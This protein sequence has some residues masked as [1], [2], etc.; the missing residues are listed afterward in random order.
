[1]ATR[2]VG[3]PLADVRTAIFLKWMMDGSKTLVPE[4]SEG[5]VAYPDIL[6]LIPGVDSAEFLDR[7]AAQGILKKEKYVTEILCPSCG[8]SSLRDRYTCVFCHGDN[9]ETGE[10]IEHY[11]CGNTDL[12]INFQQEGK[13]ICTKCRRELKIIG[14]DYRRVGKV[15]KCD[16][17]G[18]ESSIPRIA[19]SCQNCGT[20]STWEQTRLLRLYKYRIN[21]EKRKEIDSLTGIYLPL[22]EFLRNGGFQVESP[23]I[24]RGESGTEHSFDILAKFE[25]TK[26]LFDMAADRESVGEAVV[27]GLF[28]KTLDVPHDAAVLICVPKASNH[29]RGLCKMYGIGL[30]EGENINQ[31]LTSMA[32]LSLKRPATARPPAQPVISTQA[33]STP[34][35]ATLRPSVQPVIPTQAVSAPAEV[36]GRRMGDVQAMIAALEKEMAEPKERTPAPTPIVAPVERKTEP[37]EETSTRELRTL[38]SRI[39][40]L[41]ETVEEAL[42]E[43]YEPPRMVQPTIQQPPKIEVSRMIPTNVEPQRT[44]VEDEKLTALESLYRQGKMGEE[45][46]RR[47]RARLL[48]TLSSGQRS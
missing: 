20:V 7:L 11:A 25:E 13:L 27:V 18:K 39:S 17:C 9:I 15:F 30:V 42:Q 38:R 24:L 29:A 6:R 28:S 26:T 23:V 35:P 21:E 16:D 5:K 32:A 8:S 46:Y 3:A 2:T 14:T 37:R 45:E 43:K 40:A 36:R 12:E 22:I 33:V 41:E 19:H 10:M 1:M 47:N 44:A 31:I 4:E 48:R 34:T